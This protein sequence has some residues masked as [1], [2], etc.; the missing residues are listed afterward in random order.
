VRTGFIPGERTIK[1][2]LLGCVLTESA[3]AAEPSPSDEPCARGPVSELPGTVRKSTDESSGITWYTDQSSPERA[4]EDAFFLYAGRRHC[5]V[6]LR[7]RIQYVS[8]K[9][10]TIARLTVKADDKTFELPDAHFKHDT[11]GKLHLHWSDEAVTTDH[12]LMLF[13][14]TAAKSVVLRFGG[15]NRTD[16]RTLT[17]SEKEAVKNILG[18]YTALGGKL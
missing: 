7:L 2:H 8:D 10:L 17:Q 3:V 18:V 6:W 12:L 1:R 9:S 5:D 16:E 13:S 4:S 11:D 14:V 15:G